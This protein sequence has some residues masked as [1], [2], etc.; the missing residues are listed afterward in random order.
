MTPEISKIVNEL[1][2]EL[3]FLELKPKHKPTI[4]KINNLLFIISQEF[5]HTCFV[6]DEIHLKLKELYSEYF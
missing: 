2:D 1:Y 4:T 6:R 5:K 3:K